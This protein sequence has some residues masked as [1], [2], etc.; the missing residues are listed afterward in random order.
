MS[1]AVTGDNRLRRGQKHYVPLTDNT[2]AS[3][4]LQTSSIKETDINTV[5]FYFSFMQINPQLLISDID[6]FLNYFCYQGLGGS[7]IRTRD[8][9][10]A[11]RCAT[12][13]LHT[14][15]ID[16]WLLA[17]YSTLYSPDIFIIDC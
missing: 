15:L 4:Y 1:R 17:V 13:E 12:S 7:G 3:T 10:T 8:A 9:A 6:F 5:G 11:A 2:H 14:S 16:N